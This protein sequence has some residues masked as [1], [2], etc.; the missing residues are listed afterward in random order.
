MHQ[1]LQCRNHSHNPI[2][3]NTACLVINS[4]RKS[5]QIIIAY[6]LYWST[7]SCGVEFWRYCIDKT[8]PLSPVLVLPMQLRGFL[9]FRNGQWGD[10]N[11]LGKGTGMR[12]MGKCGQCGEKGGKDFFPILPHLPL[13]PHLPHLPMPYAYEASAT[14]TFSCNLPCW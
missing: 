12:E 4:N 7:G 9:A 8:Y 10:G 3:T 1:T 13:L 14:S 2:T 5:T 11:A 6:Y